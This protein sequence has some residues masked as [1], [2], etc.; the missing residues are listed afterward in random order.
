[1]DLLNRSGS[2]SVWADIEP[3]K[4]FGS[5]RIVRK[6]CTLL[7][8]LSVMV[9]AHAVRAGRQSTNTEASDWLL[10][11]QDAASR[12]S[13]RMC[14]RGLAGYAQAFGTLY[15]KWSLRYHDDIA[16]GEAVFRRLLIAAD[17][18]APID[19]KMLAYVDN[20][21]IELSKPPAETGPLVLDEGEKAQCST[22]LSELESGLADL[23]KPRQ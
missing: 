14:E 15:G 11:L 7:L 16:R 18:T 23:E 4:S 12:R 9:P 6:A 5:M 21:L 20:V 2:M 1:M 3:P 10:F 13:A 17:K 22:I 8:S 19:P